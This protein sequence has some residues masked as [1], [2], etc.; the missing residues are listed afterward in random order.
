VKSVRD[1]KRSLTT[2]GLHAVRDEYIRTIEPA[3]VPHRRILDPKEVAHE[4]G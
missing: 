4:S 1:N 3:R 2:A